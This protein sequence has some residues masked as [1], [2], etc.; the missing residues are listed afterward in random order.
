LLSYFVTC[1]YFYID[2]WFTLSRLGIFCFHSIK[3]IYWRR[4]KLII[5]KAIL[6]YRITRYKTTRSRKQIV[7]IIQLFQSI[8][9]FEWRQ[10]RRV[11]AENMA[12]ISTFNTWIS[13]FNWCNIIVLVDV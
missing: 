7:E 8:C 9:W 11:Y 2:L 6:K 4:Q 12:N 5:D 3:K 1:F 10:K 13:Q